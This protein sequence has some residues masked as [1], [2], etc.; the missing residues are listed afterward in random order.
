MSR[1]IAELFDPPPS[2]WGLRGDPYL[3]NEL[4]TTL[5]SV[6]VPE[7]IT[8]LRNIIESEYENST[9]FSLS[10]DEYIKIDRL[11]HGG[12]SSGMICPKFWREKGLPLILSRSKPL[13]YK[14]E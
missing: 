8:E 3:W 5:K 13:F 4:K 1:F 10:H 9:G 14:S 7:T 12:M 11:A 6:K 2:A